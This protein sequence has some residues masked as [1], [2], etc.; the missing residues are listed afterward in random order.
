MTIKKEV[1]KTHYNNAVFIKV[2]LKTGFKS[3]GFIP[4]LSSY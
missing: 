4:G 2:G 1:I 3:S